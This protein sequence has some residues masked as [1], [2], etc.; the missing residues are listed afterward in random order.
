V[1]HAVEIGERQPVFRNVAQHARTSHQRDANT[2]RSETAAD[3]APDGARAHHEHTGGQFVAH[4][5][6]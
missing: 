6:D 1:A 3:E 2:R 4:P 5:F